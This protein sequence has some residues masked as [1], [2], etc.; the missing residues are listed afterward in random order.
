MDSLKM[1]ILDGDNETAHKRFEE[2]LKELG[3]NWEDEDED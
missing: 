2:Y 1:V 3:I